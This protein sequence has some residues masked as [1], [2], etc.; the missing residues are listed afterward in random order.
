[1]ANTCQSLSDWLKNASETECAPCGIAAAV[2]EYQ[3]VLE[4]NGKND[5]SIK[6]SQ[7]LLDNHDPVGKVAEV[8]DSIKQEVSEEL[9]NTLQEIDCSAQEAAKE[10]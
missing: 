6:I 1:M 8:M 9:K 4:E 5:L 7:A 2:G 3:S 10:E